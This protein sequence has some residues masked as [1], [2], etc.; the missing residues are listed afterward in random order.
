MYQHTNKTSQLDF[1]VRRLLRSW[2]YITQWRKR[3]RTKTDIILIR[4]KIQ[5]NNKINKP[6]WD[7]WKLPKEIHK[8]GYNLITTQINK[9]DPLFKLCLGQQQQLG[10][11]CHLLSNV[12]I[13]MNKKT[14]QVVMPS[15]SAICIVG[16]KTPRVE[17]WM[18]KLQNSPLQEHKLR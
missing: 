1:Q 8:N 12:T 13:W 9:V 5:G 16:G 4:E 6:R 17:S 7:L 2:I 18:W 3:I 11:V 14:D 15:H 10:K